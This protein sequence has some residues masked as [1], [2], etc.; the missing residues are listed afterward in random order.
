MHFM[1]H[2]PTIA[3]IL[4]GVLFVMSAVMV[5]FGLAPTPAIPEGTPMAMFMGALGRPAT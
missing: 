5:L 1:K 4:L 3:G 2:L